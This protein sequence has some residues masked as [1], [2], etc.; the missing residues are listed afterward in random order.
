MNTEKYGLSCDTSLCMGCGACAVACMDE[1]DI[2]LFDGEVGH[3]RIRP[4][5][6]MEGFIK[7]VSV[8]CNHCEDS[9]CLVGC[10]TGAIYRDEGTGAVAINRDICIGC[11]SCALACPYGVPR[12]DKEDKLIKCDLCWERQ[13]AGREPACARVCPVGALSFKH[14]AP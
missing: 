10:P 3:R 1:H 7:W 13:A 5:E 14:K 6:D 2:D 11:H 4:L 8:S 9:P 12:Y